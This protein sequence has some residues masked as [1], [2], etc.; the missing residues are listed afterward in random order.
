MQQRG[1]IPDPLDVPPWLE[2]Y[3]RPRRRKKRRTLTWVVFVFAV[4]GLLAVARPWSESKAS[5]PTPVPIATDPAPATAVADPPPLGAPAPTAALVT[6]SD[7]LPPVVLAP[8]ASEPTEPVIVQPPPV[9]PPRELPSLVSARLPAGKRE[10]ETLLRARRAAKVDVPLRE[11]FKVPAAGTVRS[12]EAFDIEYTLDPELSDWVF[13]MLGRAKVDLGHVIVADARTGRILT[14]ASTDMRRFPPTRLY[15]AASLVKVVTAA[16]ALAKSPDLG[17]RDCRYTGSPYR[18]TPARVD[19]PRRGRPITFMRALGQSNNQCFAQLAVHQLGSVA[20]LTSIRNF[21]WLSSPG[22]GHPAGRASAGT[23]PYE[24]GLLGS[25]LAGTEITPLHALQMALALSDGTVRQPYWI[26]RVVDDQGT[27]VRLQVPAEGAEVLRALSSRDAARLR[28]LM[29]ETTVRGTARRAFR[30]RN[31]R[32][33]LGDIKVAAKTG[34]LTGKNPP[35][36]YDWFTAVA[37]AEDPRVAITVLTIRGR[38]WYQSSS[39]LGAQVLK[40]M[41]CPRG[42]CRVEAAEDWLATPQRESALPDAADGA[43]A[44]S[45]GS[46]SPG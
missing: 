1:R 25:G 20:M 42:R 14:Y 29:V 34:S 12:E 9:I 11:H 40:Q 28:E 41:F 35:G 17:R 27:T 18:L 2:A 37:P 33:L 5:D 31:G 4:L 45:D 38:K 7:E 3:S 22:A 26:E 15:P 36:H 21:G 32:S 6:P 46:A 19:P 43:T 24:L 30:L 44:S 16:A 10:F 13:A 8:G 23:S 39:Q